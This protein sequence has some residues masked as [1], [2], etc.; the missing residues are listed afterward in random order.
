MRRIAVAVFGLLCLFRSPYCFAD[1][2]S[3][4]P[5]LA[6]PDD[7]SSAPPAPVINIDS[8]SKITPTPAPTEIPTDIPTAAPEAKQAPAP[9]VAAPTPQILISPAPQ[10]QSEQN[11]QDGTPQA[12]AALGTPEMVIPDAAGQAS[13]DKLK[14][15]L[16]PS[17]TETAQPSPTPL[18]PE[19]QASD[20]QGPPTN[21][22]AAPP[23]LNVPVESASPAA[24][25]V[26]SGEN[27]QQIGG[28]G[29]PPAWF[30][31]P[32]AG[33]SQDAAA[34]A[35]PLV[36]PDLDTP[37]PETEAVQATE[38]P[39]PESTE[40]PEAAQAPASPSP[41]STLAPA[42]IEA[43]AP[44]SGS[45]NPGLEPTPSG[46]V[47]IQLRNP[48]QKDVF[49]ETVEAEMKEAPASN[50]DDAFNAA[51]LLGRAKELETEKRYYESWRT[52][53]DVLK[54]YPHDLRAWAGLNGFYARRLTV[55]ARRLEK[56]KRYF[57]AANLYRDIVSRDASVASAWWGLGSIFFKYHKK[58]QTIY[59]MKKVLALKPEMKELKTW[60][61]HYEAS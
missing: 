16:G 28:Q 53:M 4:P 10:P 21:A 44:G 33:A 40:A 20:E 27:Y 41:E 14:E 17:P 39:S 9:E 29:A 7:S 30:F 3:A 55:Q 51:L 2:L 18:A 5:V 49:D 12:K 38:A 23:M 56:Q 26:S 11:V 48:A 47:M 24:P 25:V 57:E 34:P 13:L 36:N 42:E 37:T 43:S 52:Y 22:S 32:E 6:P 19:A 59:C 58:V 35:A 8:D 45:E 15:D 61:E 60:L 1:D 54:E 50:P 46:S 31:T